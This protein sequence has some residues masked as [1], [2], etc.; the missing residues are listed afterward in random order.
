ME[1]V[2]TLQVD[3]VVSFPEGFNECIVISVAKASSTVSLLVFLTMEVGDHQICC[4]CA[5]AKR[6][7]FGEKGKNISTPEIFITMFWPNV[8]K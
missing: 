6:V 7:N 4:T 3:L 8:A 1:V 5:I 2:P